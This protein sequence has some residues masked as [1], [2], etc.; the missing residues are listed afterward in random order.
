[1]KAKKGKK[2]LDILWVDIIEA[3]PNKLFTEAQRQT[4]RFLRYNRAIPCAECNKKRRVMWTM[5]CTF[6]AK[7][8]GLLALT[9]S[10]KE[11]P[12]LTPVCGA[13]PLAPAW[14]KN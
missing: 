14:P 5:I 1:M 9:D 3:K 4:V 11:H 10:G 7:N 12:P 8:M 13:H 6:T 2:R